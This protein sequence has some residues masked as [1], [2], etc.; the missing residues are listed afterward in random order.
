M[1][2]FKTIAKSIILF[3]PLI[4]KAQTPNALPDAYNANAKIN[5][6]RTFTTTAPESNPNNLNNRWISDINVTTQ[7]FDGL[8]RPLQTVV[9]QGALKTGESPVDS[10]NQVVYDAFGRETYKYLPFAANN[11]GGN[12][13]I[14][15]G[16]FKLNPFQQNASFHAAMFSGENFIYGQTK[17]EASPLARVLETFAPGDSWVGTAWQLDENNRHSIKMKYWTNANADSVKIWNVVNAPDSFGTY[18]SENNYAAGELF[19][20]VTVDENGKQVIEF[21]DKDGS[22]ILKKVQLTAA[23][24]DGTG[25]GY[26]GWLCTY[27]IYDD[28]KNLRCVIQPEGVKK[29]AAGNWQLSS[30][31]L[32]EQCFRYEYDYR[33]RMIRKK[34]PGAGEV[35]MVYDMRDRLVMT[36][37]ADMRSSQNWLYTVYDALNRPVKTGIINDPV[38]YNH[39]AY[40]LAAAAVSVSYPNPANYAGEELT[41]TFYDD[42]TWLANYGNPFSATYNNSFDPYFETAGNTTWPY[43]QSN[44]QSNQLKGIVTGTRIKV[45][46]TANTYLYTI[47]YYDNK[48]RVIQTQSTN[49]TGGTGIVTT[50]YTWAGQ[51]L[52]IVQQQQK[53]G[54]NAQ[55][56]LIVTQ[57][58]Y[59]DLGRLINVKKRVNNDMANGNVLPPYKTVLKNEYDES[60]QLVN[61][62][63]GNNPG[64]SPELETL[65]YEYNIRGWLLGVNREYARDAN[66]TNYFGFDLGYDRANNNIAGNTLYENP[67]YNGNISGMVWKSKGDG[68]K[69]KYDFSYDA[70]NRLTGADFNQLSANS[71]SKSAG[72]DF[73][74]TGLNYDANGN[75]LTLNQKGWKPGGSVTIDS[76]LYTYISNSN[77]LLNVIDRKN[78]T[79]TKL[80]DFRSS[81]SYMTSL[82]NNKTTAATDYSY[83]VNGNLTIDKNK[84]I[85]YIHYNY[86]NL[87]DSIVV[88]GKGNIKYVYDAAGNKLKKITTEGS[89]ITTTLYLF[90]NYVN[91]TLQYIA[92]EEG[93]IRMLPSSGGAGGGLVYDYF[94]KDHLGNVR[95][96]LTEEQKTDA[97]PPAS[98]ET[99]QL[100]T[101]RMF[102]SKVDSGRVNKST[103]SGYPSDT[104]TS[105]ND[106]IQKLNGNGVKVGTGIVLKVMAGDKFNLRVSSWYKLN[107]ATPGTPVNPLPDLIAA[108]LGSVGGASSA[109]GG[110]GATELQNSGIITTGATNFLNSQTY[111]SSRPKAFINWIFLDEQFNYYG[112]GFEQ[113]GSNEEFKIHTFSDVAVNKNGYLYI[114]VSNETPNID[115]YFDNLQVTHTRGALLS[116]DHYYPFGLR[117]AGI[118]SKA[119]NFGEPENKYK[120]NGKELQSKEFSDGSGL[121]LYDMNAR[122]YDQQI[123]RFNGIDPLAEKFPAWS[124][125]SYGFCNPLR[126]TDPT[127]AEPDDFV[128]RKDGSIYWD[129]NANDQATTK[130]GET[131]LGKTLSFNFN[132][133]I[134]KKLWDGPVPWIGPHPAGDKLTSTVNVTGSENKAGELTGISANMDKPIIG[135]TPWGSAR[136]YFPGLGADQN[137]FT[138]SQSS[139]DNGTLASFNLNYEQH[140]SVSGFEQFGLN[141]LGYDIVNVAQNLQINYSG[142]NF[143]VTA[144]T[145][146][147]PSSTLKLNGTQLF[148]YD[149]PSFRATHGFKLDRTIERFP[150][151]IPLRPDPAFYQRYNK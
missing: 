81:E 7:Y 121:E 113:A 109:H 108:M 111:N 32:N 60:G 26:S 127:G 30:T 14:S 44:T 65:H 49:L 15:D 12:S 25:S 141:M 98:M 151:E 75:I 142:D 29:L 13:H 62:K 59:D 115:V 35:Y 110:A 145:D 48:A 8:G 43:P 74:V 93:R 92:H 77:K 97:Y 106:F 9:K 52:I 3:F 58:N 104:Y 135:E 69:R 82:G 107:G 17:F 11:T 22:V 28:L 112:G 18:I 41:A 78:D 86:L 89:K 138:Y 103:V 102:Y 5:Y 51:P 85:S 139:N 66:N 126:F 70:A 94:I 36:Q 37:D 128:K 148:H 140:A 67:Q 133:Y 87:P 134:D 143:K 4:L 64:T 50:Q 27:Y 84:D 99:A 146:I 20:N 45:L 79:A 132:S 147:F 117:Q 47:S 42:Y 116:E 21:K 120:Y 1:Y 53:A 54:S 90:G 61:K 73:S 80:G 57:N 24:D 137:K 31:L 83:D 68:E 118:S 16:A 38:H 46:G 150:K 100:A 149:Q 130:A 6:I 56:T 123:G 2:L 96:V 124:P 144:A 125:Y 63:L 72:V 10:V 129:K 34:V 105:P 40:H 91:D 131:Y 33:K 76:L 88:T 71:F 39:P 122:Y 95:M 55:T 23:A 119:L 101:E 136:D 19:K 114:Y